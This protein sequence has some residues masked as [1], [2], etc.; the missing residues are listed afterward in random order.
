M[1][2][3]LGLI[4]AGFAWSA[5]V[6]S[7]TLSGQPARTPALRAAP[8]LPRQSEPHWSFSSPRV[9]S[10]LRPDRHGR[11]DAHAPH[12]YRRRRPPL[13]RARS[14]PQQPAQALLEEAEDHQARSPAVLRGHL[15]LAA[16]ARG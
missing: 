6:E 14:A 12:R 2:L 4:L 3:L 11:E 15:P 13:R 1:A 9:R 16:A 10:S 5:A 8:S 7:E